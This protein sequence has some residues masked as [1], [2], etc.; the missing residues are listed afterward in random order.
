VTPLLIP[1]EEAIRRLADILWNAEPSEDLLSQARLGHFT[2][3]DD[4][5]GAARQM[6]ADPQARRGLATFYRLWLRLEGAFHLEKDPQLFP[7]FSPMVGNDIETE[8]EAFAVNVTLMPGGTFTELMTAPY[9]YINERIA[10][11]YGLSGI[12]GYDLRKVALDPKQRAGLLTQPAVL[13]ITQNRVLIT[14]RCAIPM[15]GV[16]AARA[17]KT[18][19]LPAAFATVRTMATRIAATHQAAKNPSVVATIHASLFGT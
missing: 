16:A 2:T 11:I 10:P 9:S 18:A 15:I 14:R 19:V 6:L 3:T 4:L 8:T 17:R 7:P 13:A 5:Y 12:S 1:G